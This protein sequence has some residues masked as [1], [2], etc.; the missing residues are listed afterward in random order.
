MHQQSETSI[1]QLGGITTPVFEKPTS[2]PNALALRNDS[3]NAQGDR[4]SLLSGLDQALSI[5]ADGKNLKRKSF[6]FR[7]LESRIGKTGMEQQSML[8]RKD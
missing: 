8:L 6:Y 4:I 2:D 3:L 5:V 7:T 1:L